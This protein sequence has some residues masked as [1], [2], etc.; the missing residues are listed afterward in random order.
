MRVGLKCSW[1]LLLVFWCWTQKDS[2]GC[3]PLWHNRLVCSA[4]NGKVGGSSPPRSVLFF[5]R[6]PR[7]LW[8]VTCQE[9]GAYYSLWCQTIACYCCMLCKSRNFSA[10]QKDRLTRSAYL[11]VCPTHHKYCRITH[12]RKQ[13]RNS[14][15]VQRVAACYITMMYGI[16]SLSMHATRVCFKPVHLQTGSSVWETGFFSARSK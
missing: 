11:N 4:V 12:G 14:P 9:Y 1:S 2:T 7:A 8:K 16:Y 5:L 10:G 15:S 3:M 6:H 13:N